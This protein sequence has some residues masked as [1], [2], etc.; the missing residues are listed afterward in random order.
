MMDKTRK[1]S[2]V[3][4]NVTERDRVYG[5]WCAGAGEGFSRGPGI[6]PETGR[7]LPD[8]AFVLVTH[9]GGV[10]WD[11]GRK[12]TSLRKGDLILL[13]PGVRHAYMPDPGTGWFEKWVML[14][15]ECVDSAVKKGVF[16]PANPILRAESR[17]D[18][19]RCF[20]RILKS[21]GA[22]RQ[23]DM[24]PALMRLV[25]MAGK[26]PSGVSSR[27]RETD[28]RISSAVEI[29]RNS[30]S[31][32]PDFNNM[33]LKLGMSPAHFRREF[34]RVTGLAPNQYLISV[35]IN[36][37]KELLSGAPGSV[38]AAAAELG[39]E[40]QY[41]FSRLFK[42]KTGVSPSGWSGM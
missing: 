31:G 27:A 7:V 17:A 35:K 18:F 26:L 37:A 36:R 25:V 23:A 2:S 11:S 41:Y 38:K 34:K 24:I 14:N 32:S 16:S 30:V 33:A 9:G 28:S 10:Y 21:A 12:R 42:S 19:S 6:S 4:L 8:Y 22:A 5:L 39:F 20:D 29:L 40:D 1:N 15:G 13:F 3:Y